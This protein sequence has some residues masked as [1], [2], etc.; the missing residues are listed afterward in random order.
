MKQAV[1]YGAGNI[2][3]GFFAALC[4]KSGYEITFIDTQ[5]QLIA[6]LNERRQYPVRYVTNSGQE[7]VLVS[8]VYA[9]DGRNAQAA[10]EAI[11]SANV[12]AT[13]VGVNNIGRIARPIAAGIRLRRA[14]NAPPLNIIICENQVDADAV[15]C[16]AVF[17]FLTSEEQAYATECIGFVRASVGRMVPIQTEQMQAGDPLRIVTEPYNRLPVD[18]DAICGAVPDIAGLTAYSPF[19]FCIG[20]KLYIHNM[21]HGVVAYLGLLLGKDTICEAM[22]CPVVA[23]AA[24]AAMQS[25]GKALG[26]KYGQNQE[27]LTLY[28]E[29]L[30]GR[31]QNRALGDTCKRVAADP[32]RKLRQ[33]DRLIGAALLCREQ[34]VSDREIL[35]GAAAAVHAHLSEQQQPITKEAAAAALAALSGLP[36]G[37]PLNLDISGLLPFL[38]TGMPE[39]ALEALL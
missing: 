1:M 19:D 5:A 10:A 13:A 32:V 4:A 16:G 31:F 3:R 18:A 24:A 20:E 23:R 33:N 26:M 12:L 38:Y 7:D 39:E 21:G 34:G 6:Q 14:Q 9:I 30:I 35:L 37:H 36:E 15:L 17:A 25:S 27:A 22:R 8:G 29:D 28:A 11:A 2:G